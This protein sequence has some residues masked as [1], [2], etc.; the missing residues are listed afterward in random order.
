MAIYTLPPGV[1]RLNRSRSGATFTA[2]SSGFIIRKKRK[3]LLKKSG[4]NSKS[5]SNFLNVI[6]SYRKLSPG[7]KNQ[8][9]S[10]TPQFLRT[11]SL[12]ISYQ[13][14]GPQLFQALNKN[15]VDAGFSIRTQSP[16]AIVF[17]THQITSAVMSISPS[18][19]IASLDDNNIPSGFEFQFWASPISL[20]ASQFS[21]PNDYKF[22]RSFGPGSYINFDLSQAYN[23]AFGPGQALFPGVPVSWYMRLT[24]V[25]FYIQTGEVMKQGGYLAS[26]IQ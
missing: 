16:S 7:Q 12:G 15:R 4:K 21:F 17:P 8:W 19:I 24:S 26:V 3:P 20:S 11:S 18:E 25:V 22:L 1:S 13:L 14:T 9:K 23:N 2:N 5:K 6:S 10:K